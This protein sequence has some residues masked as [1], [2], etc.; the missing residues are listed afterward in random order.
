MKILCTY[1][2]GSEVGNKTAVLWVFGDFLKNGSKDI[3]LNRRPHWVFIGT[4]AF[5]KIF[6][7]NP[8]QGDFFI[9]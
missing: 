8:I 5:A 9:S 3:F 4:Q 7:A 2:V 1:R 6:G